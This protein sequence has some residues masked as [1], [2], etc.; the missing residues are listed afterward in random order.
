M[1]AGGKYGTRIARMKRMDADFLFIAVGPNTWGRK[2]NAS[3]HP[4]GSEGSQ[5]SIG[6][7]S[8]LRSE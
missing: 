3:C 1:V 5:A 2:S 7:D 8:S 6:A 4:E